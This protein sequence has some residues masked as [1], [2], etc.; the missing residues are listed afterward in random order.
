M[1]DK[2]LKIINSLIKSAALTAIF[3]TAI[4]IA[5]EIMPFIKDWLKSIF[6][7]HWI[8]K[9]ILSAVIFLGATA[10]FAAIPNNAKEEKITANLG[11]L[12]WIVCLGFAV[13]FGFYVYETLKH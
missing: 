1:P 12:F 3:I 2:N 7:H 10:L 9:G 11:R 5:G 6:L 13:I 8:G 4:T